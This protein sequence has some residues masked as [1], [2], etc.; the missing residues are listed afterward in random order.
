MGIKQ[1]KIKLKYNVLTSATVRVG[2]PG[3]IYFGMLCGGIVGKGRATYRSGYI[4][5]HSR[6]LTELVADSAWTVDTIGKAK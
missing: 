3:T 4:S 2:A 1:M 6:V 5:A